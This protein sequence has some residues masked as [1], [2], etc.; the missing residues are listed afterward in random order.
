MVVDPPVQD[1]FARRPWEKGRVAN[2]SHVRG[3]HF[4]HLL[5]ASAHEA[6][7]GVDGAFGI[8]DRLPLGGV[9]DQDV[10][11]VGESDHAGR[12]P[13]ALL[14]GNDLDLA[15]LHHRHHRVRRAQV[16]ADDFFLC[17]V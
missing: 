8:G 5:V 12:D 15:A 3:D 1:G 9:A 14:V 4:G 6:F 13:V 10:A 11:L 2:P 7:D 16:D 17:H